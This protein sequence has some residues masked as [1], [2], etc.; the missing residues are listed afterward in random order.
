MSHKVIV[1][2]VAKP[3]FREI[4]SYVQNEFGDTVWNE[5]NLAFKD[6]VRKIAA[7][8]ENG[9]EIVELK[10][11][12]LQNF[13]FRMVRQTKI[14]YEFNDTEVLVHMFIQT[15]RDFRTHL[16]KRLFNL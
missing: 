1:L 10:E 4:R 11:I 15:R 8:P 6:M 13:R 3:D 5:V 2:D 16:M 9:K 12:G 7:H 14:V